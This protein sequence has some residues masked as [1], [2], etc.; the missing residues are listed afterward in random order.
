MD[1]TNNYYTTQ[2]IMKEVLYY[3][4]RANMNVKMLDRFTLFMPDLEKKI[5]DIISNQKL[6]QSK[7]KTKK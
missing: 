2:M 1:K 3:L 7:Q 5:I 4:S 6:L